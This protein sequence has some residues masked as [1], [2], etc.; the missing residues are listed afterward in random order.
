MK[1][2]RID[3][4]IL[5]HLQKDGRAGA[6]E[7]GEKVGLSPSPC[8]RRQKLLEERGVIQRYVALVD[9]QSVGLSMSVFVR[10]TMMNHTD[11]NL[12]AFEQAIAAFPEVMECYEMAGGTDY[13]LRVVTADLQSYEH[14]LRHRLTPMPGVRSFQ[15]SFALKRIVYRTGLPLPRSGR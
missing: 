1:L 4:A 8:H 3:L 2:D 14:F 15:S 7:I 12:R 13:L 5:D 6:A 10:V 11:D 9:Q